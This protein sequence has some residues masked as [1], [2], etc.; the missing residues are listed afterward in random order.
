MQLGYGQGNNFLAGDLGD[1]G[2]AVRVTVVGDSVCDSVGDSVGDS[3][4]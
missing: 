4:G 2:L 3:D 1:A